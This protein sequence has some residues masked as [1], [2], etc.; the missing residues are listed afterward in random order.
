LRRCHAHECGAPQAAANF[1]LATT[2][3]YHLIEAQL[4][5]NVWSR[6]GETRRKQPSPID[7]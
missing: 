4:A 3:N 7:A 1:G 6:S 5:E 2:R